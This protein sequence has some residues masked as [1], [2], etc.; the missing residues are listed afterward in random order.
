MNRPAAPLLSLLLAAP[1]LALLPACE[2]YKFEAQ[3]KHALSIDAEG[4]TNLH[5][6]THNGFIKV[7]GDPKASKVEVEVTKVARGRTQEIADD[8]LAKIEIVFSKKDGQVR[9]GYKLPKDRG[10]WNG[11]A[12]FAVTCP[13][14]LNMDV[15]SHNGKIA[16]T[17]VGKAV[18]AQTHNGPITVA[19]ICDDL[20]VGSHNGG[21]SV[22]IDGQGPVSGSVGTHNGGVSVKLA[23]GRSGWVEASTHN[24]SIDCDDRFEEVSGS[25]KALRARLGDAQSTL[26]IETHNGG[27]RVSRPAAKP[28]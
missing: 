21:V 17:G 14:G 27:I 8:A 12:S 9:I 24:G 3:S 23:D 26:E 4:V 22:D 25:K 1:L 19:G 20:D 2:S 7:D 13:A 18:R 11:S 5:C 10:E 28:N 16:L 15:E 6:E